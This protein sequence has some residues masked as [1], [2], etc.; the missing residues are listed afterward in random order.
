MQKACRKDL[1][2][3]HFDVEQG[4]KRGK[5]VKDQQF[6]IFTT[7][8]YLIYSIAARSTNPDIMTV[9]HVRPHGRFIDI[10]SNHRRKKL[11]RTNQGSDFPG[12]SFSSK[13]K[14]RVPIQIRKERQSQYIS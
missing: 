2:W 1:S 13:D 5:G 8:A 14:V 9:F 6:H 10:K 4:F 12:G 7:V 3:L 11:H